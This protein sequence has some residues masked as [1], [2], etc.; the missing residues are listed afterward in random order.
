MNF[1]QK[2]Y[3]LKHQRTEAMEAA[4]SLL[5][6]KKMDDWKSKMDEV[7]ELNTQIDA[8]EK[9]LGEHDRFGTDEGD[10]IPKPGKSTDGA[11]NG[12]EKACK[13]FADAARK[14][15]KVEKAAGDMMQ[16]GVDAD[17]GYTVPQDI[18]SRVLRQRESKESL[19]GEVTVIPVKTKSGQRTIKKR[20]QHTGFAT[21]AEAAKYGKSATPQFA[22]LKYAV[23]KRGG[24]LP[25]TNELMEDS[26]ENIAAVAEEWLGDEA[27]VTAN[28]QI[29]A[30]IKT[31]AETDLVDLDGIL[32]AW[33]KLGSLFRTTSKLITNDDG[34]IWLTTL[35]DE[36]GR[37]LLSPN[38]ADPSQ[39]QICAGPHVLPVKAYDNTT[40]ESSEDG[41][42]PMILGDLKEGVIY[43][44]R[45]QF[46]VKVSDT[47][48]VGDFNAFEQD[49][50][51][52]RGS[53]RDD[54]TT[55]DEAAFVN[56]YIATAV[57]A[58]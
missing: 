31:K 48:V 33:L 49:L 12:Y 28:N 16:E 5:A 38:P 8:Y 41:K 36:N 21:V 22:T 42:I 10:I 44:D 46:S 7:D 13:S 15:F 45:Q 9:M 52:W 32:A 40:L 53:L 47:A 20:G 57:A 19:L 18:V 6:E 4:K 34:L 23:E 37:Y 24:Y 35:K 3:E 11:E 54:C 29:I 2:I 17:G 56:G 27:R 58:G 14:G 39:Y 1:K 25:V 30:Q 43:W 50:T 55:K 26:D 51:L